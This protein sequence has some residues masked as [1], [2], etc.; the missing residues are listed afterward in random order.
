MPP[1]YQAQSIVSFSNC[2]VV[3]QRRGRV[4]LGWENSVGF[5]SWP[6]RKVGF[7]EIF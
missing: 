4:C 7:V 1:D 6:G 5:S 2:R 3:S